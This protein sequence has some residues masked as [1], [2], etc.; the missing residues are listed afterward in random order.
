MALTLVI[1][2]RRSGKS[3][4]AERIAAGTGAPVV[5][6]APLVVGEDPEMAARVAAHR[7]RRP[8]GWRTIETLEVL[9]ALAS[10]PDG[11]TVLLDSL[12]TWLAGRLWPPGGSAGRGAATSQVLA[13]VERLG[14]AGAARAG[15]TIVVSEEAGWGPVPESAITRA[16]LDAVG[17]ACQTLAARA[18][19]VL[20]VV[21]G[22]TLEL[23]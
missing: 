21:A 17:E 23:P 18:E 13:D 20:L 6:V 16:W 15:H 3:A 11:D 4:V 5:Y 8:S 22:R 19:R 2:P 9:P 1:G 12:G 7:A 14:E 10:V